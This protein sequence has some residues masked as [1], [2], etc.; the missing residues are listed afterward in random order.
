MLREEAADLCGVHFW[1]FATTTRR[2]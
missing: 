1:D 2:H